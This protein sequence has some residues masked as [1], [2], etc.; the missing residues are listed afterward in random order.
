[1]K[2]L[3]RELVLKITRLFIAVKADTDWVVPASRGDGSAV[4]G[5]LIAEAL[6]TGPAVM[7]GKLYAEFLSTI[8]A[9]QDLMVRHPIGWPGS[10]FHKTYNRE[11]IMFRT[12]TGQDSS[13]HIGHSPPQKLP[14]LSRSPCSTVIN[15]VTS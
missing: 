9:V 7:F 5:T 1:M 3:E 11:R 10:I 14:C 8:V 15:Q 2:D 6:A 4:M 12:S 13:Q